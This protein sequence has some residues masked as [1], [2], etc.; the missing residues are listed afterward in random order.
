M[1]L[2]ELAITDAGSCTVTYDW[3]RAVWEG[4][5]CCDMIDNLQLFPCQLVSEKVEPSP[6]EPMDLFW[7]GMP[8]WIQDEKQFLEREAYYGSLNPCPS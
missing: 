5:L 2:I 6:K 4:A 3:Q 7:R 8:C 1:P